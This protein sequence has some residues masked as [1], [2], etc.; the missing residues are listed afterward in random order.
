MTTFHFTLDDALTVGASLGIDWQ[1]I[2]LE[3]FRTG[4]EVELEHGSRD[5]ATDVTG[6]DLTKTA[7]ITLAHL[8]E[9]PDYYARLAVLEAQAAAFWRGRRAGRRGFAG[10]DEC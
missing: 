6:D 9:V 10:D 3:Q 1:E 2:D 5:P 7:K 8:R 4:L